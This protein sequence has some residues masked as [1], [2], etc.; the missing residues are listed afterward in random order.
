MTPKKTML[1]RVLL[2]V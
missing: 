1:T 2:F